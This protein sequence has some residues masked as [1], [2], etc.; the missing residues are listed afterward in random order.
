MI[1]QLRENLRPTILGYLKIGDKGGN[2]GA[3]RWFRDGMKI[4]SPDKDD[5]GQPKLD[6]VLQDLCEQKYGKPLIK[7][8]VVFLTNTVEGCFDATYQWRAKLEGRSMILCQGNGKIAMRVRY[9]RDPQGVA[10]ISRDPKGDPIKEEVTCPCPYWNPDPDEDQKAHPCKWSMVLSFLLA[11]FPKGGGYYLFRTHSVRSIRKIFFALMQLQGLT[12]SQISGIPVNLCWAQERN[13]KNNAVPVVRVEWDMPPSAIRRKAI[14]Q[15]KETASLAKEIQEAE[16]AARKYLTCE[17]DDEAEGITNEFY[18]TQVNGPTADL[19]QAP[20][21]AQ[22]S[23]TAQAVIVDPEPAPEAPAPEAADDLP[24]TAL[25]PAPPAPAPTP[26]SRVKMKAKAP[27]PDAPVKAPE[28]PAPTPAPAPPDTPKEQVP[29]KSNPASPAP[30]S[31]GG[32]QAN[33]NLF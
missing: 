30:A 21:P 8:P 27:A 11:D 22:G 29:T 19:P 16:V 32:K 33:F 17:D 23:I 26:A 1:E 13:A 3:P 2:K 20:A 10:K 18:S 6:V 28:A 24:P 4:Y 7:I 15:V 5:Q 25:E 14:E 9:T 12:Y 31:R